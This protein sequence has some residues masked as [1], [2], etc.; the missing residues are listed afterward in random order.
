MFLCI[1][2]YA[3]IWCVFYFS[4]DDFSGYFSAKNFAL[5]RRIVSS[6]SRES[7]M[8]NVGAFD[9]ALRAQDVSVQHTGDL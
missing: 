2:E 6:V 7:F 1:K 3:P 5:L 9:I 8:Q 4:K